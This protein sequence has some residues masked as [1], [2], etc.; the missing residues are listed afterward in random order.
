MI[1]IKKFII[2]LSWLF[3]LLSSCSQEDLKQNQTSSTTIKGDIVG[4]ETEISLV[5]E[6]IKNSNIDTLKSLDVVGGGSKDG[7]EKLINGEALMANSSV[8]MTGDEKSK[9][10]EKGKKGLIEIIFAG[11]AVA[12]ITNSNLGIDSLSVFQLKKIF[13]GEIVNW[14]EVGGPDLNIQPYRRN[15]NSGTHE[16]FWN[17]V[18]QGNYSESIIE[19]NDNL[20][21]INHIENNKGGIGYLGVGAIKDKDGKPT[22]KVW[23]VN[24][25]IEGDQ[26][27]SPYSF[28]DVVYGG[29]YLSRPLYQYFLYNEKEL[30]QDFINFELSEEGQQI[31]KE[32]GFFPITEEQAEANNVILEKLKK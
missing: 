18:V 2:N 9:L 22:D 30:F 12:V 1:H 6:L 7:I 8:K 26:P 29:Y 10:K 17:K 4:S 25:F 3:I 21:L 31:I 5:K 32:F 11:D 28:V 19:V 24:I 20:E 16:F 23:A 14:K 15:D 13:K 27:K